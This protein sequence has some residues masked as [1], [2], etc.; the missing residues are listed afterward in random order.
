MSAFLPGA[1]QPLWLNLVLFAIGAVF[2]WRAGSKLS[3]YVDAIAER[4][5]LGHAFAGMLLL[6]GVTSLPEVATSMTAAV[7]GSTALAVNNILGGVAMQVVILALVDVV[8]VRS[9][10]S[11]VVAEAD[12]LLQAVLGIL[13][14]ALV[15]VGATLGDPPWPGLGLG[16][17]STAILV[18]GVAS[19]WIVSRYRGRDAWVAK[20]DGVE[21]FQQKRQD[22]LLGGDYSKGRKSLEERSM[23]SLVTGLAM[24]AGVI[25]VGGFVVARSGEA[26]AHQTGL[27]ENFAGAV[28]VAIATSLPEVSTTLAAVRLGRFEMAF[29]DIFGTNLFDLILIF[30]ID[31]VASGPPVLGAVDA[32]FVTVGACLGILVTGAYLVGL[33]ERRDRTILRMGYGSLLALVFYL[34][35]LVVLYRIK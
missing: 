5:Q 27:G 17:I 10:I 4:K 33:L 24:A 32:R 31:A 28:L 14:L 22:V 29:G 9:S 8:A 30:V 12:V 34:G 2:V 26:L 19:M 15:I 35:G 13:L 7:G 18:G 21:A 25:L 20:T 23:R 1:A 16:M 6:G 3:A 11:A